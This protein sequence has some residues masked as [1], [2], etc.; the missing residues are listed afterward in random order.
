MKHLNGAQ[1]H[2]GDSQHPVPSWLP[3][4]L[5]EPEPTQQQRQYV[6]SLTLYSTTLNAAQQMAKPMGY[7]C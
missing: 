7:S 4:Q 5:S 3:R 6:R 1:L 2:K